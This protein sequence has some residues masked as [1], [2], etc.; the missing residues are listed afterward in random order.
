MSTAE[1][2]D[3]V[4]HYAEQLRKEGYP[5]TALYLFGSAVKGTF[6]PMS[7]IDVAVISEKLKYADDASL[8]KLWKTR[9]SVDNRIEPHGFTPEEFGDD[10]NPL[11]YEIKKTGILVI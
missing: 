6:N 3:I 2:K 9:R 4:S 11:V 8:L 5:I 10:N 7:D 1:A